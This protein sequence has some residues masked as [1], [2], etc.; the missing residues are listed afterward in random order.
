MPITP[1]DFV[2]ENASVITMDSQ[3]PFAKGV[4]VADGKITALISSENENYPIKPGGKRING[5]GLT[6]LPGLID[7][8]CH[9]RAQISHELSVSCSRNS[10]NSIEEIINAIRQE[11]KCLPPGTWIRATGYDPFYLKE[12]RHPNRWDLDQAAP[13]H[14]VRLRHVTRHASV[15]NSAALTLAG[16]GPT[17]SEPPGM[18]VD[19]NYETGMP[20]GVI[21]GGDTWLSQFVIP[22]ITAA[23]LKTGA[24]H[25]QKKLLSRGIT[26]VQDA[27]PTNGL[28]DL[29][30][31]ANR[32]DQEN[33][34][35]PI[36][37]MAN[38]KNHLT[39]TKHLAKEFSPEISTRLEMG[40]VKVVLEALPELYPSLDELSRIAVTATSRNVPI[41]VHAV[42][43]E[44]VWTA[45]EAIRSAQDNY[46]EKKIRHRI[47]H[48]SLCPD[49]F[50]PAISELGIIVVTNPSLIYNHGDRYLI[51]VD[52][53]EQEW[54]YRMNSLRS[55]N[56]SM[57]AGSDAP[58]ASFDPWIGIKTACIRASISG[59]VVGPAEKLSRWQAL[60]MYTT[61][62]ALAGG[63]EK[64]RGKIHPGY[65]A[66]L[67]ALD[68]DPL[69]C[70]LEALSHI[71]VLA[72]WSSGN[73]VYSG[74]PIFSLFS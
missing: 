46:P 39:L 41:A 58:I 16:I 33:W 21:Y 72:A 48:L 30:F 25:L 2:I 57:A 31:W 65:Q 67:I 32:I 71:N 36:Q 23:Q 7:A 52:P 34:S 13:N 24:I 62:A 43:P 6:L 5:K 63:W 8:H 73:L 4:A 40:S 15:L 59:N 19:R 35:I 1:A 68:L 12:E 44:M 56:I 20:T 66:D 55:A 28:G 26:S 74:K 70:S 47:E 10:I 60:K 22:P 42:D 18:K 29:E 3:C 69:N 11:A 64:V 61:G 14:P 49:A 50:L 51:D 53:L 45:T 9:L 27:T 38:E 17:S 54:L 37:L